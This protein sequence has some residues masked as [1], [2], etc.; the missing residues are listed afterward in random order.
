MRSAA[1][2]ERGLYRKFE[3]TRTDGESAPGGKH[4]HCC[5]FVLDLDH[6]QFSVPALEAYAAAC[7]RE[8]PILAIALRRAIHAE[9]E[10][11]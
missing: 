4:E 6:D 8:F 9:V 11:D 3:V 5:Y 7:E 2:R 10:R 1:D